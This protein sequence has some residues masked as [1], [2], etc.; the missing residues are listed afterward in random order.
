[1]CHVPGAAFDCLKLTPS[2]DSVVSSPNI[3]NGLPCCNLL[4]ETLPLPSM[5][6]TSLNMLV[7]SWVLTAVHYENSGSL[8]NTFLACLTS[9]CDQQ[10]RSRR[11]TFQR[12]SR[13]QGAHMR[14]HHAYLNSGKKAPLRAM[15]LINSPTRSQWC[16]E[17]VAPK[18]RP[19]CWAA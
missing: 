12:N 16:T 17:P 18:G 11:R 2:F 9:N 19:Q 5:A 10:R 13:R 4:A 1:M 6:S 14:A 15:A 8:A 7:R 3:S